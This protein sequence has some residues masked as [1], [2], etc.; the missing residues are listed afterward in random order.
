MTINSF[1]EKYVLKFIEVP[2]SPNEFIFRINLIDKISNHL[3]SEYTQQFSYSKR[4]LLEDIANPQKIGPF[5]SEDVM[6]EGVRRHLANLVFFS[7]GIT[8]FY[9]LDIKN[10]IDFLFD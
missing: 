9:P 2:N 1:T 6:R 4:K 5:S 3:Y 8:D 10:D 7:L